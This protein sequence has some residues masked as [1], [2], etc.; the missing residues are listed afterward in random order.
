MR[1]TYIEGFR[2]HADGRV[3]TTFTDQTATSQLASRNPN[4]TNVPKHGRLAKPIRKMFRDSV[5]G[6]LIVEWDKKSYHIMT[7]GWCARDTQYM[8]IGRVDMHSF[9]TWH[10]LKLPK[11]DGLFDL[12][13]EELR[14]KLEWLKSDEKERISG[15]SKSSARCWG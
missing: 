10:F 8:R 6:K 13:D 4:V 2:P 9:V 5:G 1:G 14:E 11:A 3:H 7:T 15:I 12:P